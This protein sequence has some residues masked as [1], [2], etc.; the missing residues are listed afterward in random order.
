MQIRVY[1]EDTDF[2]GVVY[3]TNYIKYCERAR[4]EL[5]FQSG[6]TPVING[7][8]FVVK[9]LDCDFKSFAYFGDI[10]EVFIEI[11]NIKGASIIVKQD[12][13]KDNN[14]IF[15]ANIT[16]V[17]VKDSKVQR[18]TNSIKNLFIDLVQKKC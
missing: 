9:K 18:L 8:H 17:L 10:L 7:A 3:H 11:V 14:I 2:G 6:I 12:I 1:Y 16:L 5:F 15:T 4:S 13:K